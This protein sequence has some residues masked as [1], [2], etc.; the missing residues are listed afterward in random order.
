MNNRKWIGKLTDAQLVKLMR[1]FKQ[2]PCS[3]CANVNSKDDDCGDCLD[4]QI[5]WMSQEHDDDGWDERYG[6][7][8]R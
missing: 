2:D 5:K 3:C 6:H 7:Y 4:G 8:C 1:T